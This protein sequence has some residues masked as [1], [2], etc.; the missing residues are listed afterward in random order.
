[1]DFTVQL[2]PDPAEHR[3]H[4]NRMAL[5]KFRRE[6]CPLLFLEKGPDKN[7]MRSIPEKKRRTTDNTLD[8][9]PQ[10]FPWS[11]RTFTGYPNGPP[12]LEY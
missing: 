9:A 3:R 1:M 10:R 4:Q 12:C 7:I 8:D 5:C 2:Q 11:L 6:C